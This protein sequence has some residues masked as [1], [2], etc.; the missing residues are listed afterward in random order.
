MTEATKRRVFRMIVPR[1]PGFNVYS[2]IAKKTT[3]LGPICVAT[4]VSKMPGWDVEIIDENNYR[5][6]GPVDEEGLPDH[7]ALQEIRPADAVGFY[8]GLSCIVPRLMILAAFYHEAGVLT[9]GGGHHIDAMPEEA[10][11]SGLDVAVNGEGEVTVRELLE[12]WD[13]GRPLEE[14]PGITFLKNGTLVATTPREPLEDFEGLPLPDFGL[15]RFARIKVFPV[16]RIRGCGM[17]CEFCA[18]K[19]R[20]RCATPERLIAQIG[21]LAEGHRAREFFIVD[22]QFAQ[23]RAETLRF[24][25]MLRDYQKRM[26]LRFFLTI[27]IRLDCARDTELLTAMRE[28]GIRCVAVGIESPIDEELRAMGKQLRAAEMVELARNYHR[29]GFL[30][31]GMF[32]FGYPMRPGVEFRMSGAE[33]VRRFRRFFRDARLDTVQVLLP[34][35]LPGTA[36][37][38]R[39]EQEGRVLPHSEVG[40]EYYDGNFPIIVPD[41]PLTPE[42]MHESMLSLMG[43][44]YRLRRMFGVMVQT[45]HFPLAMLPLVNLRARWRTWYRYW[46]NEVV[47]SIGYFI[48]RKWRKAFREGEFSER[49]KR[50][51]AKLQA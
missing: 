20:A 19:G 16:S 31:H 26:N 29:H 35:P 7:A 24:C 18:V 25:Q 2:H 17:N 41:A 9:L 5:F 45:L 6:P 3:A 44:F 14:V 10:L 49:L 15:L 42:D 28:C 8:G 40:W 13:S 39:L 23:D 12:A 37:R 46:R 47:G 22:D 34:V 30:V 48:I 1:Y 38:A 32:I 33:R 27:Q 43:G 11:R 50:G 21:Y 4:S 51:R 36:L